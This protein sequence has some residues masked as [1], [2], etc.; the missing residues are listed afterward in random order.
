VGGTVV[1][2]TGLADNLFKK[3][4]LEELVSEVPGVTDIDVRGLAVKSHGVEDEEIA[5]RIA[6]LIEELEPVDP[7]TLGFS[8]EDGQVTVIGNVESRAQTRSLLQV[9]SHL[10][11]VT[12]ISD[13]TRVSAKDKGRDAR[14]AARVA[15]ALEAFWPASEM[16]ASCLSGVLVLSGEVPSLKQKRQADIVTANQVGVQRVVNKLRVAAKTSLSADPSAGGDPAEI[17][18]R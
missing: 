12:G 15:K 17:P 13:H 16:Q 11:G 5:G 8:V 4:S 6:S 10:R 3:Q 7:R 18:D 14:I 1:A 9:L 2:L